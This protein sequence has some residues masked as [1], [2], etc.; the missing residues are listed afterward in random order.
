[1]GRGIGG[2]GAGLRMASA[3]STALAAPRPWRYTIFTQ[4]LGGYLQGSP[5]AHLAVADAVDLVVAVGS[6]SLAALLVLGGL[7]LA[8]LGR[9]CWC[10]CAAGRAGCCCRS[11][12]D[13]RPPSPGADRRS[14]SSGRSRNPRRS[15]GQPCRSSSSSATFLSSYVW[16]FSTDSG[17]LAPFTRAGDFALR[18][19][20][21]SGT[22]EG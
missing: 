18:A 17:S 3:K 4:C 15:P 22:G 11:R 7:G 2:S 13:P 21:R 10:C 5:V 19:A 16:L 20:S 1:V 12:G 9:S 6:G 8:E 14:R